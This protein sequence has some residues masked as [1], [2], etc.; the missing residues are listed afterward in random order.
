[1]PFEFAVSGLGGSKA[2]AQEQVLVGIG[3][4]AGSN[5]MLLTL[6]WGTCLI[7]G[8]C[9]FEHDSNGLLKAKDKTLTRKFGLSGIY[10]THYSL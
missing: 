4:L 8:R 6:L 2:E 5:V 9:D 1:M 10:L 7:L 3:L